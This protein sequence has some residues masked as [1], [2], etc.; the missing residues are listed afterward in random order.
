[1][2]EK[3]L[4]DEQLRAVLAVDRSLCIRAGAGCGKTGVLAY[5]Y[6]ALL[7][8]KG[9]KPQEAVAVT[10]TEKAAG[11]LKERIQKYLREGQEGKLPFQDQV[12]LKPVE[13]GLLLEEIPQAPISTLHGLAGKIVRDVS[14]LT[15]FDPHFDILD[16]ND[17]HALKA[18]AVTQALGGLLKESS[19]FLKT[20]VHTYGWSAL[21]RQVKDMLE[22]WTRWKSFIAQAPE[23]L[24]AE[25]AP[26]AQALQE[27]FRCVLQR[28]E[29]LK[30]QEGSLDFDDLEEEAHSLLSRN[31]HVMRHYRKLW[32]AFLVDEFQDTSETQDRLL[33]LLIDCGEKERHL[34]VVGD[35]KQSIYSFRGAE[36]HIFEKYQKK[37][38]ESGGLTCTLSKNFRSPPLLLQWVNALFQDVFPHY[39]PL[40]TDAENS[41]DVSLEILSSPVLGEGE[42]LSAEERR[43][44]EAAAFASRA[45]VLIEEGVK[46]REI[47]ALFRSLSS[48]SI[49]L[50]AFRER[51]LPVYVK[52]SESLLDRQEILDLIHALRAV[53]E[54]ENPLSWVGLLRSPALSFSDEQLFEAALRE[55]T[56]DWKT[57][58]P[59]LKWLSRKSPSTSP[60]EFLLAFLEETDLIRLY[61]AEETSAL[62][63]QNILQFLNWAHRWESHHTGGLRE[64]LNE[65]T[66]LQESG[67]R[68]GALSDQLGSGEAVTF[69]TIHQAKGL[70]F[71]V[72]LLPDLESKTP[73]DT[74]AVAERFK[75]RFGLRLPKESLG[76]KRETENSEALKEIAEEKKK[77]GMEE[78]NRIFYVATTRAKKKMILGFLPD[79]EKTKNRAA[80]LSKILPS[81]SRMAGVKWVQEAGKA[82]ASLPEAAFYLPAPLK[83]FRKKRNTHF[84]VTQLECFLRSKEEYRELYLLGLPPESLPRKNARG[85]SRPSKDL[86]PLERGTL[87]HEFLCRLTQSPSS[88]DWEALLQ[89]VWK[90]RHLNPDSETLLSLKESLRR[91][92]AHPLFQ[93]IKNAEEGYSEIPFLLSL[94][95]Y[96]IRGAM[97]RL[98]REG[99]S[100]KVIDYKTHQGLTPETGAKTLEKI[101]SE[102]EFQMK[103]YCLAAGRMM[104][105][106]VQEAM[107]YFVE[108]N[109]TYR[110]EFSIEIIKKHESFLINLM[111]EI[112]D[113]DL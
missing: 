70:D 35:E 2:N 26:L 16:A 109:L 39:P 52:S 99:E 85:P 49:Y 15:G 61:A 36:P 93:G 89:A 51:G 33:S 25:E 107:V 32:K 57:L 90:S 14:L 79:P 29:A 67:A 37:I 50:K 30:R 54:P 97:D 43:G 94:S 13:I 8:L 78:E 68:M 58:H 6:V 63:A 10:F 55:K 38:T 82:T 111:D 66:L 60:Y 9:L 77:Q 102:F 24:S 108:P 101:A 88:N 31:P 62:K 103:T 100:W 75:G 80:Y 23:G 53:A 69:M 104:N 56:T 95:P 22:D 71:P 41:P 76:L 47:F 46:A 12:L 73:P 84:A 21:H 92:V 86:G 105:R 19:S 48:V 18:E 72:V 45:A 4:T 27:V 40:V 42:K 5:H 74:V 83:R 7:L 110:F 98:I 11:E 17:A 20:L 59:L 96:E 81:L 1:M 28:Y 65:V 87:V 112:N 113:F 64:F 3:K 44:L 91:T 34:A 106:N